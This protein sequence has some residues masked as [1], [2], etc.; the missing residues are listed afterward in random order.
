MK[1]KAIIVDLDG[2]LCNIDHRMP[3]FYEKKWDMF[4]RSLS[5]DIPNQWCVELIRA[6]S[7]TCAIIYLTARP[8]QFKTKTENWIMD[9]VQEKYIQ[10]THLYM[11]HENDNRPDH[12]IKEEV[13]KRYIAPHYD[14]LFCVDDRQHVV[15]HWRSLKLTCLQCAPGNY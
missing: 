6:M 4:H 5:N 14:V 9:H 13:Y 2:T 7:Q 11:R 15:D 10:G 8:D 12:I 1:K 3:L